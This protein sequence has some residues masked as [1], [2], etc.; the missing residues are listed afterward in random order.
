MNL[1]NENYITETIVVTITLATLIALGFYFNKTKN[2]NTSDTVIDD[3]VQFAI[4]N[5]IN[6]IISDYYDEY[7]MNYLAVRYDITELESETSYVF[8]TKRIG[9]LANILDYN[10]VSF[11]EKFLKELIEK[12]Y[13]VVVPINTQLS[14][15]T[16]ISRIEG[17]IKAIESV[18]DLL[19]EKDYKRL[20]SEL[21][22]DLIYYKK[23]YSSTI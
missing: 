4:V 10:Q 19:T 12:K 17:K 18:K 21:E 15:I 2:K 20:K 14:F 1:N 23:K 13:D 6:E 7:R 8:K 22:E 16:E 3:K 9:T 5:F 11:G